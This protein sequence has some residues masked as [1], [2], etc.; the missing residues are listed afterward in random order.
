MLSSDQSVETNNGNSGSST[1]HWSN[2]RPSHSFWFIELRSEETLLP[3]K[4]SCYVNLK[5]YDIYVQMYIL[6]NFNDNGNNNNNSNN[7]NDD[8]DNDNNKLL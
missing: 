8:E 4:S 7:N 3:V 2:S 5:L 1:P 6:L